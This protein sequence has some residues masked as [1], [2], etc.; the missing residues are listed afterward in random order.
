MKSKNIY[1]YRKRYKNMSVLLS[2]KIK[3]TL[4][5]I[6]KR[7]IQMFTRKNKRRHKSSSNKKRNKKYNVGGTKPISQ[8]LTSLTQ[9]RE[10]ALSPSQTIG[11]I[12]IITPSVILKSGQT[13]DYDNSILNSV[14]PLFKRFG[15]YKDGLIYI[16][17]GSA[18]SQDPTSNSIEQMIPSFL[19]SRS[20][21]RRTIPSCQTTT[22]AETNSGCKILC[23][24]ID[25]ISSPEFLRHNIQLLLSR[26]E[27][28][29]L[30]IINI[31]N[32][33][34]HIYQNF[35]KVDG[36]FNR[37][38]Y[39]ML[40]SFCRIIGAFN[41][42]EQ[43][44]PMR[45]MCSNFIKFRIFEERIYQ[46]E[47]SLTL[48]TALK[49]QGYGSSVYDWFGYVNNFMLKGLIYKTQDFID[50]RVSGG[51][52]EKTRDET[53]K[54]LILGNQ[55]ASTGKSI[56][57]ISREDFHNETV[58]NVLGSVY[59]ISEITYPITVTEG[60]LDNYFTYSM[61]TLLDIYSETPATE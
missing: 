11:D 46:E 17:F 2:K 35:R 26:R 55:M 54:L 9:K 47:V 24:V 53:N 34:S 43:I 18:D 10:V 57:D 28:I 33:T 3:S 22:D 15:E 36:S 8:G 41:K 50:T 45:F 60:S 32:L 44:D 12:Q 31:D 49:L 39:A 51:T 48:Y 40:R 14:K 61:K 52:M 38:N 42:K 4:N 21:Q 27:N 19:L 7:K 58:Y 37:E 56:N 23:I 30:A 1:N 20:I 25:S 16:S 13:P 59:P 5:R 29:D 6:R